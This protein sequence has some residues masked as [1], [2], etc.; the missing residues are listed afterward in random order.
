[1]HSFPLPPPQTLADRTDQAAG[2]RRLF[3]G[4]THQRRVAVASNPHVACA[5]VLLER[6]TAAFAAQG[7]RTLV[8]DAADGAGV[9]AAAVLEDPALG[10]EPLGE[11]L[12]CLQAR[13]LA[14]SLRGVGGGAA[15]WLQRLGA[16]A[17]QHD[18]LLVHAGATDLSRFFDGR[19]LTPLLLATEGA[20]SLTHA[21]ASLRLLAPRHRCTQFDVLLGAPMTSPQAAHAVRHLGGWARNRLGL[22]LREGVAVDPA[23]DGQAPG[24]PP[25]L[26]RLAAVLLEDEE[27]EP[28]RWLPGG[29]TAR[30]GA[31][32][33]RT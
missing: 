32:P 16:A 3:S 22:G 17:P 7:C 33:A 10:I 12:A 24:V 25:M 19:V 13:G 11:S 1:M 6:L 14:Q 18:V 26:A 29:G 8:I 23:R 4:G 20:D 5:G 9:P 28:G 21:L 15:Q 30:G 31:V 2:L 27:Q